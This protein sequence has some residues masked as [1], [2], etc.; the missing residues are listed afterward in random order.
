MYRSV[1]VLMFPESS[2][3]PEVRPL[4]NIPGKHEGKITVKGNEGLSAA[5]QGFGVCISAF[6]DGEG[7]TLTTLFAQHVIDTK[8]S[9][10]EKVTDKRAFYFRTNVLPLP[11]I[12][13]N[14]EDN[15]VLNSSSICVL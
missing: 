3:L 5:A 6:C 10:T 9:F 15:I 13:V 2:S 4:L 12:R 14:K 7:S 11:R 8:M 1:Y